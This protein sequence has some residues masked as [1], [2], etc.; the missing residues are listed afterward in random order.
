MAEIAGTQ[1]ISKACRI[2][3]SFSDST[4]EL[5]LA[6]ISKKCLLPPPTAFRILQALVEEGFLIQEAESTKYSLGYGLVQIGELAKRGNALLKIVRPYAEKLAQ[7]WGETV[8][9]EVLNGLHVDTVLF[10]PASYRIGALP[11]HGKPLPSHCTAT[12]KAQL[13]YLPADQLEAVLASEFKAMTIYTITDPVRL[14]SDLAKVRE[15]GYAIAREELE[16]G[17][18]AIAAPIL[19]AYGRVFAAVSVGGPSSRFSK[20][21]NIEIADSVVEIAKTISGEMGYR[22]K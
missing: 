3:R 17:F 6:D 9:I 10:V 8:S 11:P 4:P 16:L 2:L 7:V 18:V 5:S 14:R 1:L 20:E 21:K 19:N 12:G 22:E 13:A 15:Q